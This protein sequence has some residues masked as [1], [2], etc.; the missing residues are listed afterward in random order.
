MAP[1]GSPAMAQ[2]RPKRIASPTP[3]RSS[4]RIKSKTGN[5][6]LQKLPPATL[7]KPPPT[8]TP[9]GTKKYEQLLDERWMEMYDRLRNYKK[10]HEGSTRVPRHYPEDPQLAC[11]VRNQRHICK[12]R[13][14]RELLDAI[15]FDWKI[16]RTKVQEKHTA[17]VQTE[18]RTH[19]YKMFIN[20]VTGVPQ[21]YIGRIVSY[22]KSSG[23][24]RIVYDDGDEEKMNEGQVQQHLKP[25]IPSQSPL[26]NTYTVD[27]LEGLSDMAKE[28]LASIQIT[29]AEE[30][31]SARTKEVAEHYPAWRMQKGKPPIKENGHRATITMW[32]RRVRH[33]AARV[34]AT[35]LVQLNLGQHAI[36]PGPTSSGNTIKS[37]ASVQ[38]I[39]GDASDQGTSSSLDT[40]DFT[41]KC[42][43]TIL[44][45]MVEMKENGILEVEESI[46]LACTTCTHPRSQSFARAVKELRE[47]NYIKKS[48]N[49]EDPKYILTKTDLAWL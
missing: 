1:D 8:N 3:L 41:Q 14:R 39:V 16:S 48:P 34:G 15:G 33:L 32:K 46:L 29:T 18:T 24:Y 30:F 43:T 37:E 31:L 10:C 9:E 7:R 11:W 19:V 35:D 6:D 27:P 5:F 26:S 17:E 28:Y 21:E 36:I 25:T 45:K 4:K 47:R 13:V 20:P 23:I 44:A 42:S 38:A 12:Q 49:S 2:G 22:D 40:K